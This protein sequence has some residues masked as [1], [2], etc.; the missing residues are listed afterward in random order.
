MP[1]VAAVQFIE[2]H[3]RGPRRPDNFSDRRKT[4]ILVLGEDAHIV[5]DKGERNR[6]PAFLTTEKR[7]GQEQ[8]EQKPARHFLTT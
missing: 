4:V 3:E 1:A 7:Q 5:R 6:S 2:G 8:R